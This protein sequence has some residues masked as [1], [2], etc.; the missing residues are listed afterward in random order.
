M[1]LQKR[2]LP[3]F[4]LYPR[5]SAYSDAGLYQVP[6]LIVTG[7]ATPVFPGLWV[8]PA[9]R[10]GLFA[11]DACLGVTGTRMAWQFEQDEKNV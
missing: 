3:E 8:V 1:T 2:A 5:F 11:G 6:H 7:A 4:A 10:R 9:C